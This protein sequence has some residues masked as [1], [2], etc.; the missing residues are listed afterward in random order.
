M[1]KQYTVYILANWT[2]K[3]IYIGMTSN[4]AQR[5]YQHKNK[6]IEGFTKKYNV[7]KLVYFEC[8]STPYDAATREQ[9]LKGWRREKKNSL[10]NGFNPDWADLCN[11]I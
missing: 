9:Q 1:D 5:I 10:I 11:K 8:Y 6:L 4:L 2:N 3:V 7:S